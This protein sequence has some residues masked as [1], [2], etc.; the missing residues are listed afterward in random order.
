M[1]VRVSYKWILDYVDCPWEPEELAERLTMSGLMVERME[2]LGEGLEGIVT[3]RVLSIEPHPDADTLF[4]ARVDGGDGPV[5]VVTGATNVAAGDVVP[6]ARPGTRLPGG[7]VI[8]RVTLR[9]V[10]SEGMMC[11]EAE[12]GLGD[13]ASGI[14][15][16]PGDTPVGK[17]LHDVLSLDDVVFEV[18]VHPNRPDCLG[19][20]GIAR[21]VAALCGQPLRL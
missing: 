13:D 16:L 19:V 11:S 17:L 14:M 2:K 9:G 12:L 4:V 7:Q 5:T 3:A 20:I 15:I 6:L 10:P 21:E 18:E 1:A 8:E